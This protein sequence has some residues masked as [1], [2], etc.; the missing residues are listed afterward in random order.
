M[1][2]VRNKFFYY[3]SNA[4]LDDRTENPILIY[5]SENRNLII[6]RDGIFTSSKKQ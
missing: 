5:K 4:F 3:N 1:V 2:H 6:V